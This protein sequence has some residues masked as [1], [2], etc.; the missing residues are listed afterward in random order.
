MGHWVGPHWTFIP[1]YIIKEYQGYII[2]INIL[3]TA[4]LFFVC[5]YIIVFLEYTRRHLLAYACTFGIWIWKHLSL[6]YMLPSPTQ[7][8]LHNCTPAG[9]NQQ[10]H[11]AHRHTICGGVCHTHCTW[12][13]EAQKRHQELERR[14][15]EIKQ[16]EVAGRFDVNFWEGKIYAACVYIYIYNYIYIHR[17]IIHITHTHPIGPA[18]GCPAKWV[19]AVLGNAKSVRCSPC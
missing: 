7:H 14:K 18:C 8:H 2:F 10:R 19:H 13:Q 9:C 3:Y 15:T 4:Y 1:T 11:A 12:P 16:L 5:V 17:Y 6:I